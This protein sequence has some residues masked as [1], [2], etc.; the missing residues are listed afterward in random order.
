[1]TPAALR[2]LCARVLELDA[3]ARSGPWTGDATLPPGED[4]YPIWAAPVRRFPGERTEQPCVGDVYLA[5]ERDLI[6]EY[7]TAAPTLARALSEA[8]DK[9]DGMKSWIDAAVDDYEQLTRILRAAGIE[10]ADDAVDAIEALLRA[11]D[12][13][14]ERLHDV[15]ADLGAAKEERD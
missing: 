2:A 4:K 1:M 12:A 7:R 13:E 14:I 6:A 8:L 5:A 10:K 3:A 9:T 15:L 11:R